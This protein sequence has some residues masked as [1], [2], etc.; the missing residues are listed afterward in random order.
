M[1]HWILDSIDPNLTEI[2]KQ[3]DRARMRNE[4]YQLPFQEDS[5]LIQRT[6]E[7]LEIAVLDKIHKGA[8]EDEGKTNDLRTCAG[9]A[10]ILFSMLPPK[11]NLIED[12]VF[13]LRACSLAV[14]GD[15]GTDAAQLLEEYDWSSLPFDSSDW[16]ER[17]WCTI[18]DVWLRLIRKKGRSDCDHVLERVAA[19][20]VEQKDFEEQ[21]LNRQPSRQ[22]KAEAMEL[23]CFYHLAKAAEVMAIYTTDGVVNDN[24][25]IHQ[26]L[27]THF[28]NIFLACQETPM[29]EIEPLSRLL[30]GCAAQMVT[31]IV[32]NNEK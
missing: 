17:T 7:A 29:L 6:S 10:F 15:Q 4:L 12:A 8:L 11:S 26:L 22:A 14:I 27:D 23:I 31:G 1:S 24:G 13:K 9:H 5:E 19:L 30:S 32:A 3:A 16:K 21:Y 25:Q 18:I 2:L 28:N 20:R